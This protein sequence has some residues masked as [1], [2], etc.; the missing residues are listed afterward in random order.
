MERACLGG[1]GDVTNDINA[2]QAVQFLLSG[3]IPDPQATR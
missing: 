1:D 2:I 3:T